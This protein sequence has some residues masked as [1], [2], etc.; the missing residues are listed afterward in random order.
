MTVQASSAHRSNL[1]GLYRRLD[2]YI[3]PWQLVFRTLSAQPLAYVAR[4]K[5]N[6]IPSIAVHVLA[7][8]VAVVMGFAAILH[9]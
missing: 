2:R 4:R 9:M 1:R 7:N 5:Q 8:S 3:P 6:L